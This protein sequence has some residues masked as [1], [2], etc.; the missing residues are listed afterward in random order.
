MRKWK[1]SIPRTSRAG[2]STY[3][4]GEKVKGA[5]FISKGKATTYQKGLFLSNMTFCYGTAKI[6]EIL[7][8]E[9]SRNDD[10]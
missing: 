8:M 6:R 1:K 4:G 7:G 9:A 10:A 3:V 2:L 5:S